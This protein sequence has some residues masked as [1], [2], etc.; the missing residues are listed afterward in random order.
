MYRQLSVL[1]FCTIMFFKGAEWE[2]KQD[3]SSMKLVSAHSCIC[4]LHSSYILHML[5][6]TVYR[7]YVD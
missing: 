3:E 4:D 6:S 5:N 7:G 1:H 2:M